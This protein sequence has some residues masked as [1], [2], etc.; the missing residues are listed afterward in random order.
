MAKAQP[1]VAH[2]NGAVLEFYRIVGNQCQVVRLGDGGN[3]E[4]IRAD[5][6]AGNLQFMPDPG[7]SRR[8]VVEEERGVRGKGFGQDSQAAFGVAMLLG[9]V[10]Q[11]CFNDRAEE[12]VEED[13][14]WCKLF[15][16]R[17]D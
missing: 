9:A 8:G 11:L 7:I 17:A 16:A 5:D 6:I 12:D 3:Y 14:R 10:E 15:Q 13:V 4:V 2:Q 1:A